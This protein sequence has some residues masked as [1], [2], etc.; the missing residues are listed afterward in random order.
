M[1][2]LFFSRSSLVF[3]YLLLI[4][5]PSTVDRSPRVKL[6]S[7][8]DLRSNNSMG[9][10]KAL[11]FLTFLL[12]CFVQQ[13]PSSIG[14]AKKWVGDTIVFRTRYF[15]V[16]VVVC[17]DRITLDSKHIG[18]DTGWTLRE[19][20]LLFPRRFLCRAARHQLLSNQKRKDIE[21]HQFNKINGN[22]SSQINGG[23]KILTQL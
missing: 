19:S 23:T 7:K 18:I 13:V 1:A 16:V 8:T 5:F 14:R 10:E 12:F 9:K 22:L 2:L 4:W 17:P 15:L 3:S 20:S 21:C 6:G 11:N